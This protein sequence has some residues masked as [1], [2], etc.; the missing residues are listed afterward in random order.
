MAALFTKGDSISTTRRTTAPNKASEPAKQSKSRMGMPGAIKTSQDK[1][2]SGLAN[3]SM[4]RG[5]KIAQTGGPRAIPSRK[6]E[7]RTNWQAAATTG[8]S[9]DKS[10]R[11]TSTS[12]PGR[13]NAKSSPKAPP[14]RSSSS[15]SSDGARSM[16]GGMGSAN[17]R[18]K[19]PG[20][21][22]SAQGRP[23][24]M[25]S[26]AGKARFSKNMTGTKK[27]MQY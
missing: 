8:G 26:L 13:V 15:S 17:A 6:G 21:P 10:Y 18:P 4:A 16:A 23:G 5:G 9:Q 7:S 14:M 22:S 3:P 25:E 20:M 1:S 24:T 2:S 27:S 19:A 11:A 12:R